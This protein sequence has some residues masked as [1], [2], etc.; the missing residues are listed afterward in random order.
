ME[1]NR[2][3]FRV[4]YMYKSTKVRKNKDGSSSTHVCHVV[5]RDNLPTADPDVVPNVLSLT[6]KQ[7]RHIARTVQIQHISLDRTI[8]ILANAIGSNRTTAIV[9]SELHKKGDKYVVDGEER[10]YEKDSWKNTLE[11]LC[12]SKEVTRLVDEKVGEFMLGNW[13][14]AD[15]FDKANTK[16]AE[17]AL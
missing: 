4:Q 14:S 6:E 9:S 16:V 7:V 10:T 1:I 5:F 17:V 13:E 3:E 12:L 8:D 2:N 15:P 11:S